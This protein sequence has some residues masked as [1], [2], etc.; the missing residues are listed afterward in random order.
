MSSNFENFRPKLRAGR[1]IPQGSKIIFETDDPYNQIV[2]PMGLADVIL[3]CSGQFS[4]REIVEKLY[5][6][7]RA[8][9]FRSILQ[10]MHIL[11]Q[12]GFFENGTELILNTHLHSWME[13][14]QSRWQISWRFGQRIL[15]DRRS[16]AAYYA[17]T[18][19]ILVGA[20][21]GAVQMFPTTPL[22]ALETW[23][24]TQ[25]MK[26]TLLRIFV[27]SSLVQSARHLLRGIQLLLLTGKAYNVSLCLSPWGLHLHVGD[28]TNDLFENRLYTIMFHCSQ[29]L[30]G[31]FL[32]F[33]IS[34]V[35]NPLWQEPLL[36]LTIVLTF[37]ELN[38]FANS[39]SLKLLQSIFMKNDQEIASW[40]FE[41]SKLINSLNNLSLRRNQNFAKICA[42]WGTVWLF[43]SLVFLQKTAV[44]FGPSVLKRLTHFNLESVIPVLGLGLWLI[45]LYYLVQSFVETIVVA[46]LRPRWRHLES[47]LR[48]LFSRKLINHTPQ[49]LLNQIQNLPLFSHFHESN[50]L[51]IIG[52]SEVLEF[53]QKTF[54]IMQG[55]ASR[56]L[57]IL[58]DGDV[59][60][61]RNS[62]GQMEWLSELSAVSI[63][64]EA[65]LLDDTPRAAQ[66]TAKT[67]VTLL[68]VPV[69][70]IR[71]VAEES[72]VI[73][74][75][76]DFRNAILVNQF[77]ASSPVFRSLSNESVE[78][79]C[80]RGTLDYF[81]QNQVIF[82]QGE[83]GDSIYMILRG[84][85]DV[86]VHGTM[87]KRLMQGNFFGEIALIA[88]LPRTATLI[89]VEPCV[90]FKIS[91]DA[92]WDVLVQ[93]I[94]LGIFLETISENRLI[95]DL[96]IAPTL[97]RTGND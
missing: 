45:A 21:L 65:S 74:H 36:I 19:M 30:V 47:R 85:V 5:K 35:L 83:S 16:P 8:V 54:I 71:Q 88:N 49:H 72:Q 60:I 61:I 23:L 66:V 18:L 84:S 11:H 76:E 82:N 48:G 55:D 43:A 51:R 97:K 22:H 64:G 50:L 26:A 70:F 79:L 75:V 42:I 39:E 92:F 56:D 31:W 68:R 24:M 94:D 58:L 7:Q 13:P 10:A 34:P 20:I 90:F 78:F 62:N 46:F 91:A 12:G 67:K 53:R 59:E 80:S 17:V 41:T 86:E 57:Y 73:R 32:L 28:E 87:V 15:A 25:D 40:H 1:V 44:A 9:P 3:L 37:W 69:A 27:G 52:H 93:H 77:F 4:I 6:K 81:D 33:C 89:T 96:K 29:I 95:E 63:F 14:R 2:L 38:P